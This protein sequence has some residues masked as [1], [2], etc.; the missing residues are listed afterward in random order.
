MIPGRT[1]GRQ[2]VVDNQ[3]EG[4]KIFGQICF[5]VESFFDQD[6]NIFRPKTFSVE[7]LFGRNICRSK[8][9]PTK[10]FLDRQNGSTENFVGRKV[11][12]WKK[13]FDFGMPDPHPMDFTRCLH[14]LTGRVLHTLLKHKA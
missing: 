10:K 14:K 3:T 2:T 13:D 6:Q 4:R 5:S 1:D 8:T 7:M 12:R 11:F 9:F